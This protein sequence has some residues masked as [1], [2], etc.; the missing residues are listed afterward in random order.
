M[1]RALLSSLL[2]LAACAGSTRN[3]GETLDLEAHG[4]AE[5]LR[6]R[7]YDDAA[8]RILPA[9]RERFLD[10]RDRIDKDLRIDDYEITRVHLG[11]GHRDAKVQIVYT[12]H[13]DSVGVVHE[14]T[15]E[16][17]WEVRGKDWFVVDEVRKVGE[18]MPGLS[19]RSDAE[20]EGGEPDAGLAPKLPPE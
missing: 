2:V 1:T 18:A 11:K 7:R 4:Y 9:E 20:D 8:A 12:W 5:G 3:F 13:L 14:T 6:W 10:A 19:E 15:A 16:Q 17:A